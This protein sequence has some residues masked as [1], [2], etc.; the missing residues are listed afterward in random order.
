ML[1]QIFDSDGNKLDRLFQWDT[2][3]TL[4]IS[5]LGLSIPPTVHFY[6]ARSNEALVLASSLNEG[7]VEVSIPNLLL[8]DPLPI[9][10]DVYVTNKET[11]EG[12]TKQQIRVPLTP[13]PKPE[14]WEYV[15]TIE[16]K[17]FAELSLEAETQLEGM[18]NAT[19]EANDVISRAN[20]AV[21]AANTATNAAN[22]AA[23]SA[24]TAVERVETT[25]S[26]AESATNAANDA[27][28]S[29]TSASSSANSAASSATTAAT[30]ASNAAS[31][32][33]T[34]K[35]NADTAAQAANNAASSISNLTVSASGLSDGQ[36]PTA[37]IS[38][39]TNGNAYSIAFGI[40]K[41]DT[42]NGISKIELL[43]GGHNPGTFDTYRI[44]MTSGQTYDFQ[45]YNGLNG[46][47]SVQSV[48]QNTPDANG[49]ITITANDLGAVTSVNGKSPTNGS[50]SITAS[51][52]SAVQY[53]AQ[54]LTSTQQEQVR[55]NLGL[56][57]VAQLGYNVVS[58]W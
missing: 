11:R 21:S 39:G 22:T 17:S 10:A 33:N 50:V 6:N 56:G 52:I 13:R 43:S 42:G 15:E 41:G 26:N 9:I 44:T 46:D 54:T 23:R 24:N 8:M 14:D 57:S 49:N 37:T 18:Q 36:A 55:I 32:A 20:E 58:E 4:C 25:I 40:P 2:N 28:A 35:T 29:A 45:V 1:V 16:Y 7:N 31:A 47:G 3:R 48:N 38:G 30:A 5:G 51:D 53:S 12:K 19:Q 34:A 27:A